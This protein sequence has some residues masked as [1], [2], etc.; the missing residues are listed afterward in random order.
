MATT[1]SFTP[2]NPSGSRLIGRLL[3]AGYP[4]VRVA[5]RKPTLLRGRPHADL[6]PHPQGYGYGGVPQED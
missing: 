2:N 6:Q 3:V 5:D 1:Y 4:D